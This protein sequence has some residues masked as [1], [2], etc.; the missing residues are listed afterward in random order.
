VLPTNVA[1]HTPAVEKLKTIARAAGMEVVNLS[2][3][4]ARVEHPILH[5]QRNRKY[6]SAVGL[7]APPAQQVP[8]VGEFI[9]ASN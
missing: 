3:H 2:A 1:K 7:A 8:A 5:M 6:S 4:V 9:N